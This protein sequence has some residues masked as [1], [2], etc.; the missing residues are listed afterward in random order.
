MKMGPY[1]NSLRE[2]C[3]DPKAHTVLQSTLHTQ[4]RGPNS[5]ALQASPSP[6]QQHLLDLNRNIGSELPKIHH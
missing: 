4:P 6:G 1:V 3:S 2:L 5:A